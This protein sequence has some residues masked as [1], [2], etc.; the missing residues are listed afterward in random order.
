MKDEVLALSLLVLISY[1]ETEANGR[2]EL[3]LVFP[4]FFDVSNAHLHLV[5]I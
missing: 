5:S 4:M 3:V 2:R 1:E